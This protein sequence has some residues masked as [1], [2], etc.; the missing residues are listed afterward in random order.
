MFK[1]QQ[2]GISE[3]VIGRLP[4]SQFESRNWINK[5]ASCDIFG[6]PMSALCT[7]ISTINI[8]LLIELGI[9]SLTCVVNVGL[10]N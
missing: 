7:Q 8:H 1:G 9:L 10:K 5:I 6:P 4:G 2:T 3:H